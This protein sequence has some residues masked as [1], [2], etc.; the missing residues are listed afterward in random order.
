MRLRLISP[1]LAC[2]LFAASIAIAQP[3]TVDGKWDVTTDTPHGK[4][5][6]ELDLK[7]DGS[8]V[9][10]TLLNFRG[11][12]QPVK[13]QFTGGDLTLE[14]ASGDEIAFNGKHKPDGSIAGHVSTVQG[15]V[16]F[17]AVRVKQTP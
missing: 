9:S 12:R 15:D 14:A 1:S 11:Q 4:L 16:A 6:L 10:G 8:N 5:S 7:Q 17:V 13:G 3:K 2:L